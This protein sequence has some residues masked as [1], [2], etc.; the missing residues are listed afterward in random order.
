MKTYLRDFYGKV[1]GSVEEQPNGDKILKDF[2]GRTLGKYE[3]RTDLTKDFYGR[4][5]AKGDA[6][7]MLLHP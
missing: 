6:L 5:V 3:K 2:Y 1:I 4:T 7:M